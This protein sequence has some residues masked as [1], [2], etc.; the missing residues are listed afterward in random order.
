MRQPTGYSCAK[1]L[2]LVLLGGLTLLPAGAGFARARRHPSH[3]QMLRAAKLMQRCERLIEARKTSLGLMVDSLDVNRT[4]LI[5]IEFS[6]ITST[7]G[8]LAAKR[9]AT[10]PDMAALIVK[11]LVRHRIG[12]SDTILVSMTGSFPALN[13]ATLCALEVLK[14]P[15]FVMTSV[16]ASSYGANQEQFTW[17][18]M[19]NLLLEHALLSHRSDVVTLGAGSDVGGG[20]LGDGPDILRAVA[21]EFGYELAES[22]N[23]REQRELRRDLRGSPQDYALF[24]NIGGNREALGPAGHDLPAGWI[25][26]SSDSWKSVRGPKSGAVFDFLKAGVPVLNLLHVEELAQRAGLPIDPRPLPEPGESSLY[27]ARS[28]GQ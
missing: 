11:E 3:E 16:S 21:S 10:N 12:K 27:F 22:E 13:I 2:F 15:V 19:E 26:P 1:L 14:I 8:D 5:G 7:V 28:R 25:D 24:V 6:A 18:H 20:L 9:T 23:Y 4:G 17:L